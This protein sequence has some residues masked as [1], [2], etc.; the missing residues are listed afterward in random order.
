LGYLMDVWSV[1]GVTAI[2]GILL[3]TISAVAFTQKGHN[4]L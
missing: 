2:L 1:H 4:S 3:F